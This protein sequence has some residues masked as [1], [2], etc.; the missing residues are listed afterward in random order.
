MAGNLQ[1]SEA[2]PQKAFDQVREQEQGAQKR[3]GNNSVKAHDFV[4]QISECSLHQTLLERILITWGASCSCITMNSAGNSQNPKQSRL[5]VEGRGDREPSGFLAPSCS[6]LQMCHFY[7][8]KANSGFTKPATM[9]SI[10][11]TKSKR[12]H[13]ASPE[14]LLLLSDHQLG[15]YQ[16]CQEHIRA[17]C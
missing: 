15:S 2:E 7:S 13:E 3:P 4:L 17:R 14:W 8:R 9:P 10:I 5:R 11:K 6:T 1:G 16:P 12:I